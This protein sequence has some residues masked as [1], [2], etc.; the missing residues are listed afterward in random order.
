MDR[1]SFRRLDVQGK[2]IIGRQKKNDRGR[3]VK[4]VER[5]RQTWETF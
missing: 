2:G 5:S 1:I 4:N 3:R